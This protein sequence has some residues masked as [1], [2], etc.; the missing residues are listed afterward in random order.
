MRAFARHGMAL[1]ESHN[2]TIRNDSLRGRALAIALK[3]APLGHM[4]LDRVPD[5]FVYQRCYVTS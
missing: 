4:L 5:Q 3:L 2:L 1:V